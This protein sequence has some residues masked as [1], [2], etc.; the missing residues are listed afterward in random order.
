MASGYCC[1]TKGWARRG[2]GGEE[3]YRHF[4]VSFFQF[5]RNR[6]N[7]ATHEESQVNLDVDL[8]DNIVKTDHL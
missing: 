8:T 2:I 7:V 1:G 3:Q 5:M 6:L 4:M